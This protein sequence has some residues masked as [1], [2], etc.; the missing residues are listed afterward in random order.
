[1]VPFSM[2]LSDP[3]FKLK[4]CST[5]NNSTTVQC[6]RFTFGTLIVVSKFYPTHKNLPSKW[7]WF[8]DV[9]FLN[10]GT[11]DTMDN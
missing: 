8:G 5:S 3:D 7:A 9:T 10:F 1:M 11:N 4:I 6:A 2:T